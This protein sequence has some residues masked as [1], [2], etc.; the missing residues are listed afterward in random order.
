MARTDLGLMEAQSDG[1]QGGATDGLF[2][3]G[4]LHCTGRD[5]AQNL[6]EAHKWFNLAA[7][8]GNDAAKTYRGELAREMSR[9]QVA[10]AQKL[11]R[12]WLQRH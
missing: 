12:E 11:A 3:L 8:R 6:V 7:L 5:G 9:Q 1:G 4:L 10:Q 2:E